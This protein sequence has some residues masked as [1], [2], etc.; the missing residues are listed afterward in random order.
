MAGLY[1]PLGWEQRCLERAR[2][3]D[4]RAFGELYEAY[5]GPLYAEVLL[6]R[7]GAPAAA[8]EAL[9]ETFRAALEKL[10]TYEPQGQSIFGW[11][12]RIA[13]NKATDLHR[14]RTRLR[15]ILESSPL[16]VEARADTA[17][18]ARSRKQPKVHSAAA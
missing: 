2:H 10:N 4:L 16:A 6:P 8:E 3:G 18:R 17:A 12:A 5:A 7:L 9:A 15:S 13:I 11:L 14:A 1:D